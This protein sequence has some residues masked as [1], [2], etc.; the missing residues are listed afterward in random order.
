MSFTR[1]TIAG[2]GL[3]GLSAAV[4]LAEAGLAVRMTTVR[5]PDDD[6]VEVGPRAYLLATRLSGSS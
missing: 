5:Q 3:A 1:A 6:G 2:A 4:R